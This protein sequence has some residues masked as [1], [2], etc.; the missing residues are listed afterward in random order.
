LWV[1]VDRAFIEDPR[2]NFRWAVLG[3]P[4]TQILLAT[5]S[6]GLLDHVAPEEVRFLSRDKES[7]AV[8]VEEAPLASES[9]RDAFRT[10]D[11]SLGSLW[12]SGSLGG[13]PGT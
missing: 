12:L 13:V 3:A 7:G 2:K 10:Y 11:D 8:K 6:A 4:P 1:L 9:W 5:H